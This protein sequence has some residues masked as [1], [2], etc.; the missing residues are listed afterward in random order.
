MEGIEWNL[1]MNKKCL[2]RGIKNEWDF[3]ATL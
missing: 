2:I 3:M 1:V